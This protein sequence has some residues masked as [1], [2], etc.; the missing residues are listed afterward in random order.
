[1][2][3]DDEEL[4]EL[5]PETNVTGGGPGRPCDTSNARNPELVVD[6]GTGDPQE[7]KASEK[8]IITRGEVT[9]RLFSAIGGRLE[10]LRHP[11]PYFSHLV[12]VRQ[13]RWLSR[14]RAISFFVEE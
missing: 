3:S 6:G 1:M 11:G 7:R 10:S 8:S 2:L 12:P 4:V 9:T 14:V 13:Y 5:D